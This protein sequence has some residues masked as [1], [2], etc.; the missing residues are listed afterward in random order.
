MAIRSRSSRTPTVNRRSGSA[1]SSP[2][3]P[4]VLPGSE[5]ATRSFWAPDG[6]RVAFFVDGN[7][8]EVGIDGGTPRLIA[9]G[10]FRDGAWSA[11]GVVLL[12]GQLGRPL[13]RVSQLGGEPVA[14]TTLDQSLGEASHDCGVLARRPPLHLLDAPR[15][16]DGR[17]TTMGTLGSTERRE[18]AGH[19]LGGQ[20]LALWSSAV[21][22]RHYPH[23]TGIQRGA[24]GT[25]GR[26]LS[27]SPNKSGAL[28]SR[29][30]RCRERH[31]GLRRRGV[32][33]VAPDVVR[34]RGI[35]A[36]PARAGEN[37][38]S[39]TL[40]PD[41]RSVAFDRGT[42]GDVWTLDLGRMVAG[43][44]TSDRANDRSPVWSLD[45][46]MI[47]FT[48]TRDESTGIYQRS[49]AVG[50]EDRLLVEPIR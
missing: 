7:L 39:P 13:M 50:G 45:G 15:C 47:A 10:P 17:L 38:E 46:R 3:R 6:R 5:S 33:R 26:P 34:S 2:R 41:G 40:S 16:P 25:L 28:A 14:E 18:L 9:R 22:P 12:G 21:S 30:S 19:S 37:Y 24:A 49:A 4:R 1:R 36:G 48:S 43:R 8:M 42:P 20:M 32:P 31:L 35:A 44:I 23:G 29:R 27:G 11:D